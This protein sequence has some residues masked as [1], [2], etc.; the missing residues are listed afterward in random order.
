MIDH[1]GAFGSRGGFLGVESV[2]TDGGVRADVSALVAL[3]A[4][5]GRPLGNGDG[6]AALLVRSGALLEGAVGVIDESGD[7]QRVAVHAAHGLHDV[8]DHRNG[9]FG[10]FEMLNVS[11]L[12]GVRPVGRNID[13]HER[14]GAGVDGVPVLLDNVHALL[15]VGVLGG[16]LHVLDGLILGQHVRQSEERGL[17]DGVGALAH[18]DLDGEVNGVDGVKLHVVLGDVALRVGVEVLVE[19]LEIPLAVDEE[20]AAG[21]H[22]L[23]HREVLHDV[24]RVVA[25]DE[26]GL[27]NVVRA[28]D[29]LVAEA[30]MADGDAAGLLG[31]VLEVRL[32]ILIGVVADDLGGVL[33][34][35]DGTV[36]A[37][38]PELA[39]DGAFRGGVGGLLTGLLGEGE[40]G[41]VVHDADGKLALRLVLLELVVNGEHGRGRRVLGGE[42]VAAADDLGLTAGGGERGHDVHEQRLALRA[43]LLGAVKDG[44]LLGGLGD[45]GDE[46]V[47]AERA[48]QAD[49]DKADLLAVSGQVVDDFLGHVADG[50]HRND[51][52]VGIG[53]AVVVEELVV[54]AELGIDLRHVLLNDLGQG[55]VVLVGSLAVL[56]E[57]IAVLVGAAHRR[58]LGVESAL[59]ERLD[60]IPVEHVGQIIVIPDGDLLDLVRGAEAVEEVD[61]RDAALDGGQVRHRGEVHDLLN[62]GLRQHGEAG[63]TAGV[64]VAVV[65]ENAQR[66]GRDRTGGNVEHAGQKLAGDL[67]HVGDHQQQALRGGVGG[68]QRTGVERAVHAAGGAGLG[69][70]LRNLDGGAE[71]I[72]PTLGRPLIHVVR[73]GAGR[74]DGVDCR[75]FGKCI[76]HVG[77]S[78]IAVHG[79]KLSYHSIHLL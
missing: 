46:L 9:L 78:G 12:G 11:F 52:A 75:D 30:Q 55:V 31:V 47:G 8:A 56:E 70:K 33:V 10:A 69:L 67:V 51:D 4:G 74:C 28:L 59:A 18:A 16:I 34:R 40:V 6:N 76:G 1:L 21:L 71:H 64:H 68:G 79:L 27:I 25:R 54:G 38:A 53:S 49:L 17:Q 58:M 43:G 41:N 5:L 37:E 62:V 63:L 73:H 7:R 35:A 13:L 19:L 66:V 48:E 20:D 32:D 24:G 77:G 45:G 3:R 42:T 44:D 61:E 22:V 65:A 15:H 60:G 14:A 50:A 39:L 23:H 72:L 2:G 36:A 29:G 57:D 26:V